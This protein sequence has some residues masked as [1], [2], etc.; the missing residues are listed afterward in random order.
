M[1]PLMFVQTKLLHIPLSVSTSLA[2]I[3]LCSKKTSPFTGTAGWATFTGMWKNST[4]AWGFLRAKCSLLSTYL[5]GHSAASTRK[6]S[7]GSS[8]SKSNPP[9]ML[10]GSATGTGIG[11]GIGGSSEPPSCATSRQSSFSL[12]QP[13]VRSNPMLD[14]MC[15]AFNLHPSRQ[16]S[17]MFDLMSLAFNEGAAMAYMTC[18]MPKMAAAP[19]AP[20]H[21]HAACR[22]MA[23]CA[24]FIFQV[25]CALE[26]VMME[27]LTMTL[28]ASSK[29]DMGAGTG[30]RE[31]AESEGTNAT[32]TALSGSSSSKSAGSATSTPIIPLPLNVPS[33]NSSS[34]SSPYLSSMTRDIL[35]DDEGCIHLSSSPFVSLLLLAVTVLLLLQLL[36]LCTLDPR[37]VSESCRVKYSGVE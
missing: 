9:G 19:L 10:G 6:A 29:S 24:I 8:S 5:G 1:T 14:L 37:R 30:G 22:A 7:T 17:P 16:S 3:F 31:R 35:R 25:L 4:L 21:S 15:V 23:V 28:L 12:L 32:L 2:V 36:L 26:R 20:L 13:S 27:R 18:V 33:P 11:T 34:S